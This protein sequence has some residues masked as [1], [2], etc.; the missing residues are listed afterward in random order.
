MSYQKTTIIGFAGSSVEVRET[1]NGKQV[2]N[3]SVAVNEKIGENE[4]TTWFKVTFWN[5]LTKAAQ[6]IE[7][8][9]LVLVE[10]RI[11][12]EIWTNENDTPQVTMIVTADKFRFLGGKPNN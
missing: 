6:H 1:K 10:G 3:V 11:S 4:I 2:A 9:Q 12:T 7:K 5:G 8:G